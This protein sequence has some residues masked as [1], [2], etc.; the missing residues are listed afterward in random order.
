MNR[1]FVT[2]LY[3]ILPVTLAAVGHMV[4][5]RL[6]LLS[7]LAHPVH[8]RWFGANKTW[9]GL[10]VMPV[11]GVLAMAAVRPLEQRW[12]ELLLVHLAQ[13]RWVLLGAAL[14]AA[15]A[16]FELPN[17]YLKRRLGIAPG[18]QAEQHRWLFFLLD[19]L[20]SLL[21]V[22]ATY[23]VFLGGFPLPLLLAVLM[24]PAVHVA[25]NLALRACRLRA[26][27]F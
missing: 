10:V 14:G 9:R 18:A 26:T 8:L 2:A 17:S 6:R 24:G 16:L 7:W 15:Y 1:V 27:W 13:K 25:V 21:G 20:D 12:D 23:A 5:V 4:V 19:H 3:L 11:A 22:A